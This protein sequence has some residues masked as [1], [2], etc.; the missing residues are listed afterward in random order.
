MSRHAASAQWA[1][2][3]RT[4]AAVEIKELRLVRTSSGALAIA[5]EGTPA[6]VITLAGGGGYE[7]TTDLTQPSDLRILQIGAYRIRIG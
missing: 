5:A 7:L 6:A 3:P 4:S 2:P 1:E